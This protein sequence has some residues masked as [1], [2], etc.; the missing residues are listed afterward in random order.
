MLE[1]GDKAPALELTDHNGEQISLASLYDDQILVL[2]FYPRD[3]SFGCTRQ[4]CSFRDNYEIF[5]EHGA[6]VVGVSS[7]GESSHQDFREEHNLPFPLLTDSDSQAE[8]AFGVTKTLGLIPG[9]ATFVI[10]RDG[11]ILKS[12]QSQFQFQKHADEALD[13]IESSG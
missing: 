4:A 3:N 7:D 13:I 2:F 8:E 12:F 9:R 10:D 11:E 5:R 6:E 1:K